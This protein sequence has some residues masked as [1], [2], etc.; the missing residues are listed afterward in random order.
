MLGINRIQISH[1]LLCQVADIDAFKGFWSG[2][3]RHSTG[4]KLL[5]DVAEHGADFSDVLGL[6]KTQAID[7]NII[8][9][10]YRTQAGDAAAE[11]RDAVVPLE[12]EDA[13]QSVGIID[14]AA[15]KDI[16]PLLDKLCDWVNG[17]LGDGG[18]THP[19]FVAAVFVAVFLQ[20][21][22]FARGNVKL[23]RFL[24]MLILLKAG[25]VYAPYVSLAPMMEARAEAFYRA[26]RDNQAS[27]E[28]G[29]PDWRGWLGFFLG[30]LAA[31]KDVL[32]ARL[33]ADVVE[34]KDMPELS[35][36]ILALFKDHQRLQ[37][38]DIM[39]MTRGRRATIKLRLKE[40]LGAGYLHRHGGGRSTWYSLV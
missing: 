20:I 26:L 9:A 33:E 39:R 22:P 17:A 6:L 3:E 8:L 11:F 36:R 7:R 14:V 2:V 27:L 38:N 10:L 37:M 18:E 40:L 35:T 28:A 29:K 23:V 30:L 25:Y 16:A 19:L 1:E 32:Q 12:I 13:S 21:A 15:V 4:L 24:L 31:Q 5:G 34:V